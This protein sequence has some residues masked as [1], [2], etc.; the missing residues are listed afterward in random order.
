MRQQFKT[1]YR[2]VRTA[3]W[4]G[5]ADLEIIRRLAQAGIDRTAS[6]AAIEAF[7]LRGRLS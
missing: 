1:A 3:R 4:Y 7:W 5:A 6:L 2:F